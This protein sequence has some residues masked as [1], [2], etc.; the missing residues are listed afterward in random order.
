VRRLRKLTQLTAAVGGIALLWWAG[1]PVLA[2]ILAIVCG[3]GGLLYLLAGGSDGRTTSERR[4]H[5]RFLKD[6]PP[7]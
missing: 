3:L 4:G 5:E 1:L 2:A 6:A 7:S